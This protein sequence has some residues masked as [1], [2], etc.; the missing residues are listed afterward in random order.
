MPIDGQVLDRD[1]TNIRFWPYGT[2][3]LY[4]ET[5]LFCGDVSEYFSREPVIII[6]EKQAHTMYQGIACHKLVGA[7]SIK[8]ADKDDQH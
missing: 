8:G 2:P 3:A 6:Y 1:Y 7:L 4:E 5:I